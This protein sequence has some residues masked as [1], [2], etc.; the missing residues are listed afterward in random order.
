MQ[1]LHEKLIKLDHQRHCEVD[2]LKEKV[3]HSFYIRHSVLMSSSEFSF[4]Q[5]YSYKQL[6]GQLEQ[7][8]RKKCESCYMQLEEIERL[9]LCVEEMPTLRVATVSLL[10]S[11][12]TFDI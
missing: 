7:D 6:A 10:I 2:D 5:F 12:C 1:I 11:N 4:F 8:L 3:I 9:Q